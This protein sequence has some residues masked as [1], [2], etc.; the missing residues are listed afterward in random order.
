VLIGLNRVYIFGAEGDV[1]YEIM[2]SE[3]DNA[4]FFARAGDID[5]E[6]NIWILDG[7]IE[8]GEGMGTVYRDLRILRF[9][10][11]GNITA[12]IGLDAEYSGV[13]GEAEMLAGKDGYFYILAG[14]LLA[15]FDGNGNKVEPPADP[16]ANYPEDGELVTESIIRLQDGRIIAK[17]H[18]LEITVAGRNYY[19]FFREITNGAWGAEWEC[20]EENIGALSASYPAMFLTDGNGGYDLLICGY[21]VVYGYDLETGERTELTDWTATGLAKSSEKN[22][23]Y[24]HVVMLD[25]YFYRL[26]YGEISA[27]GA[28]DEPTSIQGDTI[29]VYRTDKDAA[30]KIGKKTIT[31]AAAVNYP[32]VLNFVTGFNLNNPYYRIELKTYTD[33][34]MNRESVDRAITAFNLDIIAG[35][36][37][38]LIFLDN[39][40]PVGSYA[41]KG[42]FADIYELIDADPDMKRDDYLQNILKTLESEDGKLYAAAASFQVVTLAGKVSDVG[43][44]TG[45]TWDEYYALVSGKPRGIIPIADE[46]A[47]LSK[48]DFL[49]MSLSIKL[50]EYVDFKTGKCD[51]ESLDFIELLRQ[52]DRYPTER[53]RF[54]PSDLRGGD[55][56]LLRIEL[57]NFSPYNGAAYYEDMFFGEEITFIGY[58]TTDGSCGSACVFYDTFAV[59]N[60]AKDKDGAFAFVK[61]ALTD[62]QYTVDFNGR[63]MDTL[64][65][66]P[67]KTDALEKYC[68][69]TLLELSGGQTY[70][71]E[72]VEMRKPG[73]ND[74]L[75][76]IDLIKTITVR[77]TYDK[78]I[79]AIM[80]EESAYYFAGQKTAE[81]VAAVIQNRVS[82]YLAE[83]G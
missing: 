26:G 11:E 83:M 81:E 58:P 79:A 72:G 65:G 54:E 73:E 12:E 18:I 77:D 37:P 53:K 32:T 28:N 60:K 13:D 75:K 10:Y 44:K 27:L 25:D 22:S 35:K 36:I 1:L 82:L 30:S 66:F 4:A 40:M 21:D 15:A 70:Y 41:S 45:W 69:K 68:E 7:K 47:A 39:G 50:P 42:L 51:F 57:M 43:K 16:P 64:T 20:Y 71:L 3:P 19:H 61:Y 80:Q 49:D 56:L 48:W 9:D 62:F 34:F 14:G 67:V 31:A 24:K 55:P 52:T 8:S 23:I 2:L 74:L 59:S 63:G 38:D 5:A 17:Q 33:D 46:Y 6:G 29:S 78:R 76:I